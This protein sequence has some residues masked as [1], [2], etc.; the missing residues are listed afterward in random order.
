MLLYR[1][2]DT[3]NALDAHHDDGEGALIGRCSAPIPDGVLGLHTEQEGGG[4]VLDI[5]HTHHVVRVSR[6]VLRVKIP[7]NN[8]HE[9]PDN[10]KQQPG[11]EK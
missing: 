6:Q 2:D 3:H 10:T 1:D 5:V 9:E 11:E 8:R 4:E 7:M